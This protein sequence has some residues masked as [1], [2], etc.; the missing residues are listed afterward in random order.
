MAARIKNFLLNEL[1]YLLLAPVLVM[2]GIVL[3]GIFFDSWYKD[4]YDILLTSG[5]L[6]LVIVFIRLITWFT[7]KIRN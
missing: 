5:A 6:Y 4:A 2:I 7:K 1:A 3:Y